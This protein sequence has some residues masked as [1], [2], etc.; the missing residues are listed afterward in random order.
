MTHP[1]FDEIRALF[2]RHVIANYGRVP[3]A[4][5]R[6]EGV[7][8]WDSEGNKYVDLFPGW[9]TTLLGHCHPKVTTAV[10]RQAARLIH[11]DNVFYT[12]PQGE[13][14]AK[15]AEH[16]FGGK[17]FFCNSGAEAVEAALKLA[18]LHKEAE[19]RYKVISMLN[20]FHG[21]TM[22]A[23]TAT[24]QEAYRR[25]MPP[26]P[27]SV[28]VP[29]NDLEAVQQ[30]VDKETCAVIFEPIQGEGGINAGTE[31]YVRGLREVCDREGLLLIAD[32]VSTGMGRTGH[33]FGHQHYGIEPDV[34]ALAKSLG[35][36][37]AIGAM[38]ARPEVAESLVP[39]THAS[40]F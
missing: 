32:E 35:S 14:A 22:G 23:L 5:V 16:S 38:V 4:F 31:Q 33:W 2:E 1:S 13:L 29:F 9:G 11:V 25:G 12:V 27:G 8:I 39:G 36:G 6:A 15:I 18:R 24:G 40:T 7:H 30:A 28:Y 19:G 37:V 20:S 3:V 21:R 10:Q 17:S 26:V 34:M